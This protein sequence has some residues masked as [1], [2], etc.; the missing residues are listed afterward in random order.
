[1][2]YEGGGQEYLDP[3]RDDSEGFSDNTINT[4]VHYPAAAALSLDD[5]D[6]F[7]GLQQT[8]GTDH[9][10]IVEDDAAPL[11][12]HQIEHG[13]ATVKDSIDAADS[14][15]LKSDSLRPSHKRAAPPSTE[16]EDNDE[17]DTHI[18][19]PKRRRNANRDPVTPVT[20]VALDNE[21]DD[22]HED[23]QDDEIDEDAEQRKVSIRIPWTSAESTR[24]VT[25]RDSGKGWDEV[26][27]VS[28]VACGE[29]IPCLEIQAVN[30][31]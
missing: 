7:Y 9:D 22:N 25:A 19:Q 3:S 15:N 23:D 20:K 17:S 12:R 31:L 5:D 1:M 4:V 21:E 2:E 24:L 30:K 6:G 14:H 28:I 10:G 8:N 18:I 11:P 13:W 27:E 29:Y 26:H 16:T